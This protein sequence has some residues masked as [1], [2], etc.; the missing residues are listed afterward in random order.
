MQSAVSLFADPYFIFCYVPLLVF[1]LV[2]D[3]LGQLHHF[4]SLLCHKIHEFMKKFM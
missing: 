4:F 2:G 3:G 1:D